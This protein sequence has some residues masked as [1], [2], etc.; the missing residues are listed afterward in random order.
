MVNFFGTVLIIKKKEKWVLYFSLTYTIMMII[1]FIA[2]QTANMKSLS[3]PFLIPYLLVFPASL[4]K[5]LDASGI[6]LMAWL[7]SAMAPITSAALMGIM[8]LNIMPFLRDL[9]V[10]PRLAT[11]ILI[12]A[13]VYAIEMRVL[14]P[15]LSQKILEAAIGRVKLLQS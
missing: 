6:S 5:F 9:D 8:V 4:F 2:L 10:L 12:G 15:K 1:A 13:A 3:L 11:C 7:R 14:A